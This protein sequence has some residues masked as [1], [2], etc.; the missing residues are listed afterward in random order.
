MM[1][2]ARA[3]LIG[4]TASATSAEK[5]GGGGGDI[6]TIVVPAGVV[7]SDLTGFVTRVDL[8]DMPTG[9]WDGLLPDGSNI[10]VETAA[11]VRL[12]AD[13]VDCDTLAQTG[14]LFFRSDMLSAISNEFKIFGGVDAPDD[15]S[16]YYPPMVW[17]DYDAVFIFPSIK[18]R[19][20]PT[21]VSAVL[22]G[23]ATV[24]GGWLNLTGSGNAKAQ[25]LQTSRRTTWTYGCSFIQGSAFG[26]TTRAMMTY[27][28]DS[29]SDT[30]RS[31]LRYDG[32]AGRYSMWD[33]SNTGL[34]A[35][36]PVPAASV[37]HRVV[38][39]QQATTAR[40]IYVDGALKNSQAAVSQRPGT[41]SVFAIY[42]GTEDNSNTQRFIGQM[43]YFY[44]RNGQRSDAWIAA[45]YMSWET[46][47]FYTVI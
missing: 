11:G 26:A 47:T 36:T 3:L 14:E 2:A 10:W 25:L 15:L 33:S 19:V 20:A 18:N 4:T 46:D 24:V 45:E 12:P 30:T 28:A 17:A 9:F 32:T 37:R 38:G 23:D 29:T 35:A 1:S 31:T 13:T 8:S 39:V 44:L 43:N 5:P 41:G 16:P 7:T 42:M 22:Q 34:D 27:G 21:E 40:R 6:G